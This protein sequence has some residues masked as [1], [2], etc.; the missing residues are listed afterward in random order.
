MLESPQFAAIWV[1]AIRIAHETF[2]AILRDETPPAVSTTDGTVALNLREA[3]LNVGTEI[4]LPQAALDTIPE[5]VGQI[6]I[7][8]SNELNNAQT[9]VQVFDFLPLFLFIVTFGL[10][11]LAVYLAAPRRRRALSMVGWSLV[12]FGVSVYTLQVL[13]VRTGVDYYLSNNTNKDLARAIA[14]VATE[15]LRQ[16]ALT[17]IVYG[18]PIVGFAAL[19]GPRRWAVTLRRYN[20]ITTPA[21]AIGGAVVLTLVV[22]WWS[23]GNAFE[24]WYAALAVVALIAG[25]MASLVVQF[26]QDA[27]LNNSGVNSVEDEE[28]L[29]T[30]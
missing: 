2:V 30:A 16:L 12:V 20:P 9:D 14:T 3:V 1:T 4:G 26:Q 6:T 11:A 24:R 5:G 27:G 19:L 21:R 18:I 28:A 17:G 23:P 15:L 8:Q 7:F 25:A 29:T 22:L 13:G 10:Y